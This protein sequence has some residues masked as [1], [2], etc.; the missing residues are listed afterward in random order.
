MKYLAVIAGVAVVATIGSWLTNRGLDWYLNQS[1]I[2]S[3]APAGSVIGLVWTVIYTLSAISLILWLN[4]KK[5]DVN[6]H[7]VIWWFVANGFLNAFWS[8]LFFFKQ[9]VGLAIVEMIGLELSVLVLIW[10]MW[11]RGRVSAVLLIPYAAWV[12]FA[13]YLAYSFWVLNR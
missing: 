7:R 3:F 6:Y 12:M 13:T 4:Q 1:V 11:K 10:L 2:P 8:Y 9:Q 5:R